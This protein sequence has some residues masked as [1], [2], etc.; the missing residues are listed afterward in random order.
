MLYEKCG[1]EELMLKFLLDEEF[2]GG[3]AI[4]TSKCAFEFSDATFE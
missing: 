1:V 3:T 4:L 2:F